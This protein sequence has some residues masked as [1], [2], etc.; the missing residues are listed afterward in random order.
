MYAPAATPF[1]TLIDSTNRA[2]IKG[3]ANAT[4]IIN[5][6]ESPCVFDEAFSRGSVGDLGMGGM[7][8]TQPAITIPSDLVPED[9]D[10]FGLLVNERAYT[11]ASVEP[12]GVGVSRVLLQA[13]IA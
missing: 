11:I 3:L 9:Y 12:D 7:A 10:G 6:A 1:A 4:V 8:S 5:G 13:V 2:V